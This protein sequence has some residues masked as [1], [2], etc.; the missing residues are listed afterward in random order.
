MERFKD[1]S[2]YSDTGVV[3]PVG[4]SRGFQQAVEAADEQA[5]RGL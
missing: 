3:V 1:V 2:Q 4:A 5:S